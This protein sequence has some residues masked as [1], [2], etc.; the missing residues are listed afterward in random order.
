MGP[1]TQPAGNEG[2]QSG[3]PAPPHTHLLKYNDA[4]SRNRILLKTMNQSGA[5]PVRQGLRKYVDEKAWGWVFAGGGVK[6]LS[7]LCFFLCGRSC[8]QQS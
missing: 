1:F 3:Q 6:R 5:S 8:G 7:A 4:S 2:V